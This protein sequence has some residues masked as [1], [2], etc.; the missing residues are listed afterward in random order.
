MQRFN[1]KV[2]IIT[3]ASSGIGRACALR[4]A[5]EG[6]SVF[7]LDVA[8]KAV[9]ETVALIKQQN[10]QAEAHLCDVSNSA[11]VKATI[12]A[13]MKKHGRIDVLINVAGVIKLDHATSITDDTWQKIINVNLSGTFYMC[14][15]ALP[16]LVNSKGNI[17]NISSTSAIRGLP[18]GIAY[19][20]SKGGVS[21]L[22]KSIAVEYA[23]R[24]VRANTVCPGS[25][26]TEMQKSS[27]LPE[28]IDW[29][30][31]PRISAIDNRFGKPD[32]I[33]GVVALIASVKDGSHINGAEYL[34]DGGTTT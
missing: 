18:Y 19:G 23:K 4:V 2:V 9:N 15:E 30:L 31:I 34:V 32:D 21:A 17:V 5:S 1:E 26:A 22:T 24:G 12:D 33:A 29:K 14:R 10:G 6:A 13:C 7:C 11:Q 27:G 3:S 8:E 28:D 20:A 25:I 16:H